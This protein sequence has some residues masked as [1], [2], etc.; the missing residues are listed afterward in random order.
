MKEGLTGEGGDA[1]NILLKTLED[2]DMGRGL[3]KAAKLVLLMLVLLVSD[4]WDPPKLPLLMS[5]VRVDAKSI[6]S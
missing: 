4:S 5:R 6:T 1:W 3:L 2:A